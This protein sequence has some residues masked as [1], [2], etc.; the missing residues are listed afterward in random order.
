MYTTTDRKPKKQA[1]R[2]TANS[3]V[4]ELDFKEHLQEERELERSREG[5]REV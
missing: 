5:G 1:L 4:K 3:L 2:P